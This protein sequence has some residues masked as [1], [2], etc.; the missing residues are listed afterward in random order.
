MTLVPAISTS[1]H[2]SSIAQSDASL[3]TL[4]ET[5]PSSTERLF[6]ALTDCANL[7]PDPTSDSDSEA[8]EPAIANEG[9]GHFFSSMNGHSSGSVLP[10]AMPGSGGWITAENIGDFY[11][12]DGNPRDPAD[13]PENM[14]RIASAGGTMGNGA[15]SVRQRDEDADVTDEDV[16]LNGDETKWRRTE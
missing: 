12:E 2:F 1:E 7:H 10:P 13:L 4:S 15:G 5:P 8:G 16:R 9:D 14:A 11:D 3:S 6:A